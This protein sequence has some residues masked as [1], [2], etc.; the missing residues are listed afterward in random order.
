M[1]LWMT[2][3]VCQGGRIKS[4]FLILIKDKLRSQSDE[5]NSE[6]SEDSRGLTEAERRGQAQER[7]WPGPGPGEELDT[8]SEGEENSWSELYR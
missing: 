2:Q 3:S 1:S 4:R 6:V 7:G 5:A 8:D